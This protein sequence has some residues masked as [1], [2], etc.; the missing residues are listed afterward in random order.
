MVME[1]KKNRKYF[2]LYISF[3]VLIFHTSCGQSHTNKS[4]TQN[5][6]T[7]PRSNGANIDTQYEYADSGGKPLII[8]N[9]LPKGE[10]YFDPNGKEYFKVI[11]WTRIINE[12][13]KPLELKIDF[14]ANSYAVSSLPGKYF[15][16]LVP[17]DTMTIDK[18]PLHDYG[19]TG[20]KSFLDNNN[21]SKSSRL[22][23]TIIP[24]ESGS[25][26]VVILF[27]RGVGGPFRAGL[28][29]KGQNLFYRISRYGGT[30]AHSFIDE[31][32]I[33]CGSINLKSLMLQR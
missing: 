10:T 31:K 22:K 20:L 30:P 29:M 32:E 1:N 17:P 14:P 3:C 28:T 12:T 15:K 18:E 16:V 24:K 33:N 5:T 23:R 13:D 11:F 4:E 6:F 21:N 19:M 25:F 2:Y 7:S 8:Q 26:Y 9:S 27:D